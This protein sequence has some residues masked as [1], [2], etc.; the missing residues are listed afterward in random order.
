MSLKDTFHKMK[1]L[2][3][4][5]G[6]DMEK[7]LSGNKAAQQ[8][9]RKN[10]I[11]F[12]KVAKLYRKESVK[13]G[14]SKSGKRKAAPRKKAATKRSAPAKKKSATKKAATKKAATK[15]AAKGPATKKRTKRR[16]ARK[17]K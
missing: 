14:K 5:I 10:T 15:K 3:C 2:L 16:V 4:H 13:S 9:I 11:A 12:A 8:R 1:T 17:G 7:A 6:E